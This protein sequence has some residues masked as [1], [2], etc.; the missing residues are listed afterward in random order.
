MSPTMM[1]SELEYVYSV[2]GVK[3]GSGFSMYDRS[4]T[5]GG[6]T[7]SDAISAS[8]NASSSVKS[9]IPLVWFSSW[10][11]VMFAHSRGRSGSHFPTVSSRLSTRR[12]TRESAAAPLKALDTLANRMW[13]LTRKRAPVRTLATPARITRRSLRRWTTTMTPGAP[14]VFAT[15]SVAAPFTACRVL[16][17]SLGIEGTLLL[18]LHARFL[19]ASRRKSAKMFE[20][21][22]AECEIKFLS[23]TTKSQTMELPAEERSADGRAFYG[24]FF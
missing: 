3:I 15:S 24:V 7:R 4:W 1:L 8:L 19:N 6:A 23:L 16:D 14:S 5:G 22:A 21:S 18:A 9:A 11:S 13:S 20:F 2:P 17:G 12:A 10:R